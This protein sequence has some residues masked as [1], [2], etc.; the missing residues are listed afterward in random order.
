MPKNLKITAI[1]VG[2]R[3]RR[4]MGDLQE[5][6]RS[7]RDEGLLQPIGVTQDKEL[8]FGER[9]LRACRDILHWK[10]IPARIVSVSSIAAGEW[11]ENEVRKN[12]T[13]TERLA[14]AAAL[15]HQL[16]E[17]RGN[18]AIRQKIDELSGRTDDFVA[19]RAGF[20]NRETF[21]QAQK[22]VANGSAKLIRAMD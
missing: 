14:I 11:H 12:F 18:P 10:T 3:H 16:P 9:R 5:L 21:R 8:V 6:A 19:Q 20:G 1:K 13:V 2:H 17:R 15:Q 4:D 7:I 22:V